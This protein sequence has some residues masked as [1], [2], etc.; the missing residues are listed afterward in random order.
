M[1]KFEKYSIKQLS[2]FTAILLLVLVVV[3]VLFCKEEKTMC[4]M[5]VDEYLSSV[6]FE[7][8]GQQV[9]KGDTVEVHYIGRLE[10]GTVF[11]TSIVEVAKSCDKYNEARNYDEGLNFLVGAG[12]MIPGFDRGVEGMKIGQTKTI[13]IAPS[14]AYGERDKEKVVVV[15]KD[16]LNLPGQYDQGDILYAP[17]GQT[18]RVLK[19]TEKEVHLDSN[20]ELAGKSLI[21]DIT[22]KEIK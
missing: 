16:K 10:D 13:E 5:T 2:I 9:K 4:E 1:K 3:C 15:E 20:H 17:N 21:F 12:Q 6:D 11:D 19:V 7:G 18:V 22:V 14:D 8:A